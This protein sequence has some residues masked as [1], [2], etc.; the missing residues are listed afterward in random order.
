MTSSGHAQPGSPHLNA[1]RRA[2]SHRVTEPVALRTCPDSVQVSTRGAPTVAPNL[3][4]GHHVS[5][6]TVRNRH[7]TPALAPMVDPTDTESRIIGPT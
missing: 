5:R 1:R 4:S 6:W 2:S 3:M 7:T